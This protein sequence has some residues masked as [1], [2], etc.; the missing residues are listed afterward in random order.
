MDASAKPVLALRHVPHEG[1]GTIE[2]ALRGAALPLEVVDMFRDPIR[3]FRPENL[4]GLVVMGGPM[5]VD[6]TDR[7]PFLADEVRWI[8]QAIEAG[9]PILG[10]SL[11]SQLLAHALG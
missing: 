3:D 5:N 10:G 1:L 9:L 2:G 4:A 11:G 6:E 8:R 7:Y